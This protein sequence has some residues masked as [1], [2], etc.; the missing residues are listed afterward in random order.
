MLAFVSAPKLWAE[1]VS[2]KELSGRQ[3]TA[4]LGTHWSLSGGGIRRGC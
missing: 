1:Q 4:E 2:Q 3:G